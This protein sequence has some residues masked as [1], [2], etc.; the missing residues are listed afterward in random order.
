MG[1]LA[2][3]TA[4]ALD[5]AAG[6][7]KIGD[8]AHSDEMRFAWTDPEEALGRIFDLLSAIRFQMVEIARKVD[9]LDAAV[10]ALEGVPDTTLPFDESGH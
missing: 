2:E 9:D 5:S 8:W 1:K 10:H 3:E 6:G 7:T 4:H